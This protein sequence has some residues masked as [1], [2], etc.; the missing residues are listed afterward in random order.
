MIR[1]ISES[2]DKAATGNHRM[3]TRKRIAL[4]V[5][6]FF[7]CLFA[8]FFIFPFL[9]MVLTSFMTEKEVTTLPVRL[10]PT[11]FYL[12]AYKASL[13]PQLFRYLLN[14]IPPWY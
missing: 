9:Y 6:Y 10:F 1:Q 2:S 4:S 14:T 7:M 11:S 5:T 12:G 13:S 3:K 8:L